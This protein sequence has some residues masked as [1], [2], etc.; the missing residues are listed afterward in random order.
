MEKCYHRKYIKLSHPLYPIL[1]YNL[2]AQI[3]P[4]EYELFF[5]KIEH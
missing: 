3:H 4:K 2:Y 5:R 1:L